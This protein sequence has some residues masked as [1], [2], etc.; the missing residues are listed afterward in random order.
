[1]EL[2][3]Q[4]RTSKRLRTLLEG[5]VV[6]NNLFPPLE[7]TV[8]DLSE[9]GAQIM[10]SHPVKIPQEFELE[11][12]KKGLSRHVRL[13]WSNGASHGLLFN[14]PAEASLPRIAAEPHEA[15]PSVPSGEMAG[16]AIGDV[17]EEARHRIAQLAG[18]PAS[19]VR[20]KVEIDY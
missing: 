8:R 3:E 2:A 19:L 16:T 7:C 12:P 6:F 14:D 1:M 15:I 11:I 4:R 5:R 17:L 10:F 9:T 18:L 20:L 13:V